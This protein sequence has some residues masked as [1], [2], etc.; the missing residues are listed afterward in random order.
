VA[1]EQGRGEGPEGAR[2]DAPRTDDATTEGALQF[3]RAEYTSPPAAFA[4]AL[5]SRPVTGEYYDAGG[6]YACPACREVL[7]APAS[8]GRFLIAAALGTGAAV[9]GGLLWF[10]VRRITGYEIGLVAIVVGLLVGVAVRHGAQGRGGPRYQWL[11]VFLTYTGVALNYAPDVVQ[12]FL[13]G[14]RQ[15]EAPAAN[16]ATAPASPATPGNTAPGTGSEAPPPEEPMS[17]GRAVVAIAVWT[18]FVIAFSYA[19]PFLAGTGNIIGIL[20]IGFALFEAWKINRR[21][22][23][24]GPYRTVA[25]EPAAAPIG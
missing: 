5:C 18:L 9:L 8:R 11:A 25:T 10:G 13:E 1:D 23:L 16:A 22:V 19:A 20:I 17:F 7:E 14:G 12:G 6:K 3:E 21:L 4:C 2:T 24:Q 15:E